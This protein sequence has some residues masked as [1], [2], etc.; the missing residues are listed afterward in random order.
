MS[1]IQSFASPCES[2][3]LAL[4]PTPASVPWTHYSRPTAHIFSFAFI[5]SSIH[6]SLAFLAPWR[7]YW[8]RFFSSIHVSLAFLAP[9]R[10][11]WHRFYSFQD[12]QTTHC[13][14]SFKYT[15]SSWPAYG[16]DNN[17]CPPAYLRFVQPEENFIT[18]FEEEESFSRRCSHGY[19][20]FG[21]HNP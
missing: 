18:L 3:T 15:D 20:L 2:P 17:P 16:A 6:V 21:L 11:Y 12:G 7:F 19:G 14:I 10:F 4:P 9:W 1:V 8:H 5:R 13:C